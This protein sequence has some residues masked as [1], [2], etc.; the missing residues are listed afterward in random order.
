MNN[1]AIGSDLKVPP[2][3]LG[4]HFPPTRHWSGSAQDPQQG[5]PNVSRE[6]SPCAR[7]QVFHV[8]HSA[9]TASS[10]GTRPHFRATASLRAHSSNPA[11]AQ[12]MRGARG[13]QDAARHHSGAALAALLCRH[14]SIS[15]PSRH[16][17]NESTPWRAELPARP[18]INTCSPARP[19]VSGRPDAS[20]PSP[21]PAVHRSIPPSRFRCGNRSCSSGFLMKTRAKVGTSEGRL[22]FARSDFHRTV[23]EAEAAAPPQT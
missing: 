5:Y 16:G 13:V 17:P 21:A 10:V 2:G 6:T 12:G 4:E 11:K 7:R 19:A 22:S 23:S 1:G 8:K 3:F 18:A 15:I 14:L 20:L 9:S